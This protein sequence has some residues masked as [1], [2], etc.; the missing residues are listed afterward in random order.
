MPFISSIERRGFGST[1]GKR[2]PDYYTSASGF[3]MLQNALN[4]TS[5]RLTTAVRT[6]PSAIITWSSIQ[7]AWTIVHDKD[8]DSNVYYNMPEDFSTNNKR[9]FRYVIPKGGGTI[10][11]T[12]IANYATPNS[13]LGAC[14]APECMWSTVSYG[15]F[16]AGGF[17]TSNVHVLEFAPDKLSIA[18]SY[19]VPYLNEVYG[20]EMIPKLASGFL[21]DY[22]VA[23]TRGGKQMSSWVVNMATRSWTERFDNSYAGTPASVINGSSIIYYPIGK[24]IYTGDPS[25]GLNRAMFTDTGNTNVFIFVLTEGLNRIIWTYQESFAFSGVGMSAGFYP[26]HM[27]TAA[28]NSIS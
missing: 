18:F 15:A 8:L 14:Y 23:Y 13:I 20:T 16:V 22:A 12:L 28:Y 25:T 26:Y 5:L 17:Q 7:G 11:S 1:T 4:A 6:P 3:Y 24:P 19:T 21:N 27:S 2:V 10:T 9:L